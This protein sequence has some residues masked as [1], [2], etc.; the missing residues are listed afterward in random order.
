MAT[1]PTGRYT[2]TNVRQRNIAFLPDPN[3]G[4]PVNANY[5]QSVD[6]EKW[7]VIQ[8]GNGKYHIQNV[9]NASYA[10]V[11][12]RA[13]EGSVVEGR[14]QAQQWAIQETRVRGQFT[15][16]TTDSRCLWGLVD[17]EIETPIALAGAA[18]DTRNWWIFTKV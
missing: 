8:L 16:S 10:N 3:D 17:G 15:I 9:G 11:G 4:T 7:N 12:N 6:A 18:T 1:I 2:I 13:P 14:T 5:A